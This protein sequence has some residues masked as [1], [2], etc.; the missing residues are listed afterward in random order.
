MMPA[1]FQETIELPGGKQRAREAI[2]YVAWEC[3]NATRFGQT[4]L[5]KILW[6]ADFRAYAERGTP[7]TGRKYQRLPQ[8]PALWEM[9]PLQ[10]SMLRANEIEI[11]S[12]DLGS[13]FIEE[14]VVPAEKPAL[15]LL[16][17]GDLFFLDEAIFHYWE[18]TARE[19][20]DESHGVAW[21]THEDRDPLPY[22][23]ALLSDES[24]EGDQ[25]RRLEM[26][27]Q[28]DRWQSA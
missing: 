1:Q 7:V 8:G 27:G 24:P 16:A 9:L 21:L 23:L 18:K 15:S 6:R 28:R 12:V 3:R 11:V 19:T 17:D 4:K 26:F 10:T 5:H 14:R 25:L 20:S 13:G 22:E 2:L